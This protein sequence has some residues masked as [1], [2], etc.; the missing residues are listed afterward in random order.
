MNKTVFDAR[1]TADRNVGFLLHD[2]AR[3]MRTS[4]DRKMRRL[5]LTRS[6]WWVLTHLYFN[7]GTS[8]TELSAVLEIERA[9][10]G[11]L[12][13]RLEEK[14]WVER[15]SDRKDRRVKRIFLTGQVEP[16]MQTMR[17]MAAQVRRQLLNEVPASE[18]ERLI[19]TLATMKSNMLRAMEGDD[20]AGHDA[21]AASARDPA[22][23]KAAAHG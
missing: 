22:S 9:T 3:L 11:R 19:D 17:Q 21:P 2:I 18:Q 10:L 13:D 14:G 6:Q 7:E 4:Y 5:G 16:L 1:E 8:Q 12:L 23:R 20:A 15:R